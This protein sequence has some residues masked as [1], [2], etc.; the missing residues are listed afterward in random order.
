MK[1]EIAATVVFI[2]RMVRRNEKLSRHKIEKFGNKLTKILFD[3]YKSH[4]YWDDPVKGQGYRCIRVNKSQPLDPV[5]LQ[6]C[7]ESNIDY[8]SLE[9]PKELTIWVDPYEVWCRCGEKNQPFIVT[10]LE[11]HNTDSEIFKHISSAA[12]RASSDYYS[13]TSSDEEIY[14][15]EPKTIPTVINPKSIYQG[16]DHYT[17]AAAWPKF[18]RKKIFAE[19]Y[20]YPMSQKNYRLS[21]LVMFPRLDRY[22]WSVY[23]LLQ[24]KRQQ[25]KELIGIVTGLTSLYSGFRSLRVGWRLSDASA[26]VCGSQVSD[27]DAPQLKEMMSERNG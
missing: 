17:H 19:D 15:K 5:L 14:Y 13:G 3:K 6:A 11:S 24:E 12:E 18:I 9:L 1:E 25:E 23:S 8:S 26:R 4:W 27:A 22:H 10:R 7:I 21:N 2:S 16:H 20:S